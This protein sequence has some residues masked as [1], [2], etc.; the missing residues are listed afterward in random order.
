MAN[1]ERLLAQ[2]KNEDGENIGT[3][4]DLPLDVTTEKLQ[5]ICNAIQQNVSI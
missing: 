3:R 4:V 1:E 5:S 2:L